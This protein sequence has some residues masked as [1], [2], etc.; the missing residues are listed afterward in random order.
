MKLAA[1]ASAFPSHTYDQQTIAGGL[2]TVWHDKLQRPESLERL[3]RNTGV[4]QRHLVLPLQEY[5]EVD[6]WGKANNIWIENALNLGSTAICRALSPLNLNPQDIDALFFVTVTGVCS[7]SID[8][9]LVNRMGLS[10]RIKRNPIFGLGCVAGVAG[11]A[12]AA[13]YVR[14]FPKHIAVLLSVE[15]CSLT[16]Q[17]GDVSVANVISAGLFGDG[18]AAVVIAGADTGLDGPQVTDTRSTF[19]PNTERVMG[20]DV[21]ERGFQIVLSP[22]VPLV[23]EQN[24]RRDVDGFLAEHNLKRSDISSWIIHTGGPKVLDAVANALE[25]KPG[26]LDASWE[27]LR[28]VGNL[29]SASV[30]VVLQDFLANRRGVPGT[31]SLMAAMGPGF[32]SELVLLRW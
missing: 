5:L 1:A 11:T 27:C 23:I 21:S 13:D 18:A 8:A 7:P 17:R 12:R 3:H 14:A 6:T 10:P 24:L 4:D 9:R 20:W 30:L 19:Y 15:I 2:A 31:Y 16:W 28:Q 22:D 25:L 32:C 26:D 29:S